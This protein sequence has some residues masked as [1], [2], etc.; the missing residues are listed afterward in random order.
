MAKERNQKLLYER[1]DENAKKLERL[2]SDPTSLDDPNWLKRMA[3][4]WRAKASKRE[5]GLEHKTAQK[6]R[7]HR[8]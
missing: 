8:K 5:R 4:K 1:F 7:G 2:A 3:K 6:G